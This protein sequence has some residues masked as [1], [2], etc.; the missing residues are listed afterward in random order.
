MHHQRNPPARAEPD[1]HDEPAA[2]GIIE[3][4][5][6]VRVRSHT[7]STLRRWTARQ[8]LAEMGLR[9]RDELAARVV[10]EHVEFRPKR[11]RTVSTSA[12]TWSGSRTSV[13][14]TDRFSVPADAKLGRDLFEGL[15]PPADDG[16]PGAGPRVLARDRSSQARPA[17]GHEHDET[18]VRVGGEGGTVV[19][20]HACP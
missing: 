19:L 17:A 10:H 14:G 5:A 13:P 2:T 8:P 3:R 6:T 7:A 18:L 16:D 20:G 15:G 1:E 12:A 4:S 11:S 9:R